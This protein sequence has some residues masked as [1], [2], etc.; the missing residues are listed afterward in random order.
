MN[1]AQIIFNEAIELV[2]AGTIGTTGRMLKFQN[3][4]GTIEMIP[5][6]EAIHTY[7]EWQLLGFQVNKGEKAKARFTIW[8]YTSK[9]SKKAKEEAEKEGKEAAANP[10]YYMKEAYF[11]SQSQVS[12]I[13]REK[14]LPALIAEIP[15]IETAAKAPELETVYSFMIDADYIDSLTTA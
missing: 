13:E 14:Q 2:K 5:E 15:T 1:N 9:P 12:K 3:E 8:N 11:F 6:P 4:D 7:K 10:H